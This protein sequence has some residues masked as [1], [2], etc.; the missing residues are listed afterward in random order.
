VLQLK[1]DLHIH[2]VLSP[3]ADLDMSPRNIVNAA[4]NKGMNIIGITDHNSTLQCN[5]V[6][7]IAADF[8]ILVLA[9]AEVTSREEVHNLVFFETD[10]KRKI[11]QEFI[12][13][14]QKKIKNDPHK[15][16]HQVL[17]DENDNIIKQIPHYLGMALDAG[18][19]EIEEMVHGLD[20]LYIPA[21]I[22]RTRYGL[23][24]QLGFV[25]NGIKADALEIFNRTPIQQFLL[26]NPKLTDFSYVR[27]SDSHFISNVGTFFSTFHLKEAS[28]AEI[29]RAFIREDGRKVVV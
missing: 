5:M 11:F 25:P 21:H 18:I 23:I 4:F 27:D 13:R 2:T 19:D 22:N 17:V 6:Q 3:C 7:K 29:K 20:G 12:E 16:G 14:K 1:V 28:F 26:E 15:L 10:D 8:G 9:G 24:S